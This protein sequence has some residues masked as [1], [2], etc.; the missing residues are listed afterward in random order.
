MWLLLLI[1]CVLY[2]YKLDK[3]LL[4]PLRADSALMHHAHWSS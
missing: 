1:I 2:M 3:G 4:N